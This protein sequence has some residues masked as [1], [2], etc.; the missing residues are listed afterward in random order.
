MTR[1][2]K[3]NNQSGA[4]IGEWVTR[5]FPKKGGVER[6]R[7]LRWGW[8]H[9]AEES[10]SLWLAHVHNPNYQKHEFLVK[11]DPDNAF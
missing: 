1:G 11:Y 9:R 6:G 7:K 10:S 4:D 2:K 3:S 5:I 8:H